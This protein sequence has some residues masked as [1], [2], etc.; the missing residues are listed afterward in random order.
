MSYGEHLNK[1]GAAD[2]LAIK[3]GVFYEVGSGKSHPNLAM[4]KRDKCMWTEEIR[5]LFIGLCVEG[6]GHTHEDFHVLLFPDDIFEQDGI[7]FIPAVSWK[8]SLPERVPIPTWMIDLM[9][10][11]FKRITKIAASKGI[12]LFRIDFAKPHV[13]IGAIERLEYEDSNNLED[14]EG[15]ESVLDN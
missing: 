12:T 6:N 8:C 14:L 3:K 1:E 11:Q 9:P 7:K 10:G 13:A 5:S 2:K 15:L 4:L